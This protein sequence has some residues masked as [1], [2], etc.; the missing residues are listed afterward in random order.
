MNIVTPGKIIGRGATGHSYARGARF[1]IGQVV[2]LL[3]SL[4]L[5]CDSPGPKAQTPSEYQVK[6]VYLY[7]FTKFIEWPEEAF[8][9][10]DVHFII[11]VMG[12]DS[13][14]NIIEETINGRTINGRQLMVKL[15]NV[16]RC[17]WMSENVPN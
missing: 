5:Q 14:S 3:L 4:V 10:V 1:L 16:F 8:E 11:G 12:D 13:F 6:A 9:G 17:L 2:T 15:I 7:N